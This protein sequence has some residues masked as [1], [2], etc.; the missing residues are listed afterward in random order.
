MRKLILMGRSES[1]KSTLIQALRHEEI[2]YHKTQYID[3]SESIID[4]PGEYIEEKQLGGALAVYSCEADVIG[5]LISATEPFSLFPPNVAAMC[6]RPVIGIVTKCDHDDA[7][8]KRAE[9][10]LRLCGCKRIFF[11]SSYNNDG[12][13]EILDYLALEKEPEN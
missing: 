5:I 2:H 4:T 1:G 9:G 6:T 12:I 10:W 13:Q 8:P 3:Y 7:V 11:T